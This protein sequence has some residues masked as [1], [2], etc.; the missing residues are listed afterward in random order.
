MLLNA[1]DL[2]GVG[3]D[4]P[5]LNKQIGIVLPLLADRKDHM[6]MIKTLEQPTENGRF[7]EDG[8]WRTFEQL[9]NL[10]Y[11]EQVLAGT[12]QE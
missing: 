12:H 1:K 3:F 11:S 10:N 4:C 8:V 2:N 7:C 6:Q 5:A 9:R